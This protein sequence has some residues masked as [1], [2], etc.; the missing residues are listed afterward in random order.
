MGLV[1]AIQALIPKAGPRSEVAA[2]VAGVPKAR[3]LIEAER[4]FSETV[5]ARL[6]LSKRRADIFEKLNFKSPLRTLFKQ[7]QDE[8]EAEQVGIDRQL[9]E[10][11]RK[12]GELR[13][14]IDS[15]TPSYARAVAAAL[16]GF[17]RQAAENLVD[18]IGALEEAVA[19]IAETSKALLSVG[20]SVPSANPLLYAKA[21][22]NLADKIL[23]ETLHNG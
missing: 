23:T 2:I 15:L 22:R 6:P 7:Q 19:D 18:S 13:R 3:E 16:A 12:A 10:L 20:I 14:Q 4:A 5:E 17:R 11:N 1:S 9:D 8:L 21:L